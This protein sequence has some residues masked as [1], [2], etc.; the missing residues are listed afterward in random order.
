[1]TNWS[2]HRDTLYQ[3]ITSLGQGSKRL[4]SNPSGSVVIS[5]ASY[6]AFSGEGQDQPYAVFMLCVGGG[7][8]TIRRNNGVLMDDDWCPGRAGFALPETAAEGFTPAMDALAIAFDIQDIPACHSGAIDL[9][10]LRPA[11]RQLM[12]D[13]LLSGLM[14][15]L[16]RNAESHGAAS[17]FFD[18]GLSLLMH[19][20]TQLLHSNHRQTRLSLNNAGRLDAAMAIIDHQM[21]SDLRVTDLAEA[22]ALDTK[23]FTRTFKRQTGYTP[24]QYLTFQRMKHARRL[25]IDNTPVTDTALQVGYANPAKF[26]AAFK[27]WMGRTPSQWKRDHHV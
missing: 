16:L 2:N 25:L 7:G 3:Q 22:C 13:A 8:R 14:L 11:T 6:G 24:Y 12:D 27:H 10:E 1:M 4:I 26:A 15:A 23:T 9:E 17:A 20:V 21:G 19:R 18:H 5:Q